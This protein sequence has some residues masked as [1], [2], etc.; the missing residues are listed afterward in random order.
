MTNKYKIDRLC[1]AS[2]SMAFIALFAI[3]QCIA[4]NPAGAPAQNGVEALKEPEILVAASDQPD[5]N[6]DS[7]TPIQATKTGFMTDR[8]K[9]RGRKFPARDTWTAIRL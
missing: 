6:A 4:Q 2:A 3:G 5:V 9:E 8:I 1:R 7:A